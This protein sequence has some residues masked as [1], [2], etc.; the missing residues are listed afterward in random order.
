M[1]RRTQAERRAATRTALLEATVACLVEEG[2]A[3]LTTRRVAERAGV[4]QATQMH[5]FR[6]KTEFVS[7]AMRY[8]VDRIAEETV[9]R[10]ADTDPDDAAQRE[11]FVDELWKVH[12]GPA[13][14][15]ATELWIAA[16]TDEEILAS[17]RR[18]DRDLSGLI[19]DELGRGSGTPDPGLAQWVDLVLA[20]IRGYAMLAPVTPRRVIERRWRLA[21]AQLLRQAPQPSARSRL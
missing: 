13:F 19:V 17:M 1:T 11:R 12:H 7:E 15:A 10:L 16:R 5:Y 18:L 9:A 8:L 2:Y 21:R 14:R 20:A 6:S 4:S 3:N